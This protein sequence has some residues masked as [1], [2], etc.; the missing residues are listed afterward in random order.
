MRLMLLSIALFGAIGCLYD[1]DRAC[2]AN[3]LFNPER[4][5]CVC[6]DTAIPVAGG[7]QPCAADEVVVGGACACPDGQTKNQDNV[8]ATVA[9]LGDPCAAETGCNDATYSVCAPS[10]AGSSAGTCTKGCASDADC[11]GA[12]TC[13]TWEAAPYCRKFAGAGASCSAQ[14]DCAGGD[15]EFCE[16]YM[17]HTCFVANCT[18]GVNDCPRDTQCCDFSPYG[19][20]NLCSPVCL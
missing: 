11:D 12:Y 1:P 19:L 13:A 8:C 6:N 20:P 18:L 5:I 14:A 16:T 2:G 17:S 3:M 4:Q 9:G 7:C 10:T 15:A